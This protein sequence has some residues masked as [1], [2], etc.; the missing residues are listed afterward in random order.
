[1]INYIVNVYSECGYREFHDSYDVY[2]Y[3]ENF[4]D[5]VS[6]VEA[7][8]WCVLSRVDDIYEDCDNRFD[9]EVKEI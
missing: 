7:S 8:S 3:L 6:A 4:V 5:T 9:I 1:M 2:E